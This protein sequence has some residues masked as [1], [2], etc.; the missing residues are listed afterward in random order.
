MSASRAVC[1]CLTAQSQPAFLLQQSKEIPQIC[2]NLI[3]ASS[4][5]HI[6][7]KLNISMMS[8][9]QQISLLR[10][11]QRPSSTKGRIRGSD[12]ACVAI[13][14]SSDCL[15]VTTSRKQL[16]AVARSTAILRPSMQ[17]SQQVWYMAFYM[18]PPVLKLLPSLWHED[19]ES[20][21]NFPTTLVLLQNAG[22]IFSRMDQRTEDGGVAGCQ[23]FLLCSWPCQI[24]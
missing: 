9:R 1:S 22:A 14:L 6:Y 3:T 11:Y 24:D 19:H 5:I 15:P 20:C 12:A 10:F 18:A 16:P 8:L 23:M 21:R 13:T 2:C 4:W 17:H 7:I